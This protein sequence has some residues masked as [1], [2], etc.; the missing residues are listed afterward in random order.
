MQQTKS[1]SSKS[2]LQR[3]KLRIFSIVAGI[4]IVVG[5]TL[6][7]MNLGAGKA[8]GASNQDQES[9]TTDAESEDAEE[10]ENAKKAPI[11]VEIASVE[12]GMVSAYISSTANL[13][14]EFE[15]KVLSEVEGR[16]GTL[17]VDEGDFVRKGQQL[18]TLVRDDE[19]IELKKAELKAANA[20]MA[21]ERAQDLV[22]KELISREEY[23]KLDIEYGITTQ[24]L[25]EAQW[26][27]EKTI[28]RAPFSG[29]VTTRSTQVGQHV[30]PGDELFQ[31]TDFDPLIARIYLPEKDV[32]G[33]TEG[34][35]VRLRLNADDAVDFAGKI[36]QISPI[37]D[38]STGTVKITVEAS[39]P[40]EGVRPGSFVTVDIVRE[41]R[42]GVLLL[43]REAVIRE[44]QKAHVFVAD[45]GEARKRAVR[46]GL[47]EG[48][49][50]EAL[51][52]VE[53]GESVIIAGQGGLKDGTPVEVLGVAGNAS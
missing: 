45:G 13:V 35:E 19:R 36:R 2:R 32:L 33:L 52:G 49:L 25:A 17:E 34:R 24:E 41:T 27:M 21:F 3:G 38:T 22:D 31:I 44:L 48:D 29:R 46:L 53:A 28:F 11:P 42:D 14:A 8:N 43:P 51:S 40:P 18:A 30:R 26:A 39:Q 50:I 37:V 5:G 47:E 15:V 1:E 10:G 23:D 20:R 16:V 12:P 7:I 9:E 6:V 4:L